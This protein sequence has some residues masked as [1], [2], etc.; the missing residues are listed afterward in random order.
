MTN[1]LSLDIETFRQKVEALTGGALSEAEFRAFRVPMGVYEQRENGTYMLRCRFP[2]GVLPP[3]QLRAV[4]VA[5]RRFGDGTLHVTSRQDVQ[6]HGVALNALHPALVE[7]QQAGVTTK[8]GGGNTVRNITGCAL[9]GVCPREVLDV[10]PHAQALT[11]RLL[12]NPLSFQL[13]RKYKLALSGCGADC[14]GAAVSD[15]GFV[16]VSGKDEPGFAVYVA[17]GLGS[18]SRLGDLLEEFV[19]AEALPLVAEAVERVFDRHGNRRNRN[20]ARLRFLMER[21]GLAEFRR[22]F[23]AELALPPRASRGA[24]QQSV[25]RPGAG[26]AVIPEKSPGRHVVVLPLWLGEL[27][28]DKADGLAAIAGRF[29]DG[30]LRAMQEQNLSLRGVS[31]SDLPLLHAELVRLGLPVDDP[32]ILRDMVVCAG[33]STCRLGICLS[34][35]LATAIAAELRQDGLDLDHLGPIRVHIS[36]CPNSCGRHPLADVGLYGVAKRVGGRLVPHYVVQLGGRLGA[37]RAR[38][39]KG[40]WAVPAR[41]VP[42]LLTD[43]LR[44]HLRTA[45]PTFEAFAES[46][47]ER[48]MAELAVRHSAVPAFEDDKGYYHDWSAPQPFSLAGRG[49][50]ECGAGVFDLIQLDLASAAEALTQGRCFRAA[51]LAAR[52]LLVTRG[53]QPED[54][55]D[56]LGLFRRLFVEQGLIEESL[57][58]LVEDATAAAALPDKE[59]AFRDRRDD[60]ARLVAAVRGLYESM[61]ASLRFTPPPSS[62]SP[63]APRDH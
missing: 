8:G 30:L 2:A 1:T 24:L 49:P 26:S 58:T 36:G 34:R 32:Q 27:D 21:V 54:E 10:T 41:A 62:A 50:G 15:V 46:D 45:R 47:G 7:L 38:L 4:A 13:P 17:G 14:A 16:A 42:A 12:S 20:Q 53:E 31:D 22:L 28:A 23:E 57:G 29:G 19:T 51:T 56:A 3:A 5:S 40:N 55:I 63:A 11:D 37:G 43:L 35:G 39:A 6:I 60:V 52:A 33:A 9:A 44:T 61:D 59:N 48:V 25:E 18:R